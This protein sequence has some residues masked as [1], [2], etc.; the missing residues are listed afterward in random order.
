MIQCKDYVV[1]IETDYY[2]TKY[3][4]I[5]VILFYILVIILQTKLCPTKF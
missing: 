1:T 3:E 2:L 4:L 5:K